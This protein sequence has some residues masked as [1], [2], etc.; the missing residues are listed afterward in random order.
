[1]EFRHRPVSFRETRKLLA[2][3][4][5][6]SRRIIPKYRGLLT[7]VKWDQHQDRSTSCTDLR[8]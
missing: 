1:M 7:K 6:R 3:A 4:R 2:I 8:S 5:G